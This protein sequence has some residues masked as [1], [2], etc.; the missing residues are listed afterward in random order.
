MENIEQKIL[1]FSDL[2][3]DEQRAVEAYVDAH[4]AWQSLLNEVKALE[5]LRREMC[6]LHTA[7][8]DALAYYVVARHFGIGVSTPLQRVF[9]RIEARFPHDAAL[10][11]RQEALTECLEDIA[12]ALDPVAQFEQL[13]GFR[14]LA[15]NKGGNGPARADR[16]A[17]RS[18]G[19]WSAVRWAAVVV[20]FVALL[21]GGLF[22]ASRLTQSD[23][24]RLAFV[25]LSET[26]IEG[27]QI[28]LRGRTEA[29]ADSLPTDALYLQALHTLREAQTTTLGLF[30]RHDEQKLREAEAL[31]Q[32]VIDREEARSFLQLEA[33][34]FLGKVHLA[35]GEIEAARS[36]FETV[37][38]CKGRRTPEAV[39]ILTELQE[40]YP[41]HEQSYKVG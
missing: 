12:A 40:K 27:Y 7:D 38:I 9:D 31:L 8:D 18:F 39:E 2:S 17:V 34:F 6:L 30:P 37:A 35:Q 22:A 19:R 33:Y 23:A 1:Q 20:F 25:D 4:P 41:A 11:E 5:A 24:E 16:G 21:Y 14:I 29:L 13:S 15:E 28:A 36:N 26:E 3:T 10:R 32:Q